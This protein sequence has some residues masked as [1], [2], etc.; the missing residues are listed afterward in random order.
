MLRTSYPF[1]T[2]STL[3]FQ[4]GIL[5]AGSYAIVCA[6]LLLR[7]FYDVFDYEPGI[8]IFL[9]LFLFIT[10]LAGLAVAWS[11]RAKFLHATLLTVHPVLD[12][13]VIS[14]IIYFSGGLDSRLIFLYVIPALA[15]IIVST[16]FAIFVG[17]GVVSAFAVVGFG[18]YYGIFPHVEKVGY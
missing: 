14:F 9:A 6:T 1:S 11:K 18:E 16:R 4:Q 12:V 15:S 13:V 10:S 7:L 3:L 2:V 8:P 17:I 5:R